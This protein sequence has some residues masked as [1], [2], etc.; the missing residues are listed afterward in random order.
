MMSYIINISVLTKGL[1][2]QP[3]LTTTR[4]PAWI[5]FTICLFLSN[6]YYGLLCLS[7]N[8]YV[9]MEIGEN[10]TETGSI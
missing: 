10:A 3:Q 6:P 5:D 1:P 2:N 9:V 7:Y 4:Q 8:F